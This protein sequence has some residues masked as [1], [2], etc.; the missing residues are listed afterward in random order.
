MIN[1]W[2]SGSH[3]HRQTLQHTV[4]LFDCSQRQGI[5]TQTAD[6]CLS[7]DVMAEMM[8]K[9]LTLCMVRHR[10]T[11]RCVHCLMM[12]AGVAFAYHPDGRVR[13]WAPTTATSYAV[14][15]ISFCR[16]EMTSSSLC[17]RMIYIG[18]GWGGERNIQDSTVA[19]MQVCSAI[20]HCVYIHPSSHSSTDSV[21]AKWSKG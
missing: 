10:P 13:I 7:S 2:S 8:T 6:L 3:L 18:D 14:A 21:L 15:L 17:R 16:H 12:F 11:W 19:Q 1:T 5:P 9:L 20:T 4:S